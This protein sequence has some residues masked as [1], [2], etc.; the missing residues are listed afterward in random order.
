MPAGPVGHGP[1]AVA[2]QGHPDLGVRPLDST[3][4]VPVQIVEEDVAEP[5]LADLVAERHR[6]ANGLAPYLELLLADLTVVIAI[7][8]PGPAVGDE[9]AH[10]SEDLSWIAVGPQK[11]G[12]G[13]DRV[14]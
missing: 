3:D 1:A 12:L 9:A 14:E 11:H 13:I 4:R 8:H 2:T 6:P 5:L 10:R 7:A